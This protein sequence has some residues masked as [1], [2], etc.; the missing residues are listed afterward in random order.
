MASGPSGK[1]GGSSQA[2]IVIGI[3]LV[4]IG[5]WSLFGALVPSMTI[6]RIVFELRRIWS[7]V[8]P[9]ALLVAGAYILWA[10]K[11]GKLSNVAHPVSRGQFRRSRADKRIFGVCGGVAYYFGID[12]T[13]VRIVAV[14]LLVAFPLMASISYL[15]IA[16][17]VPQS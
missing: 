15:A 11:T 4:F 17:I 13:M 12:A 9:C 8:W 10:V 16:V 6:D 1:H 2:A 14:I 3:L 5:A 7:F